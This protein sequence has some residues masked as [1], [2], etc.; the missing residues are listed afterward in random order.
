M[1]ANKIIDASHVQKVYGMLSDGNNV[2][3]AHMFAN[4]ANTIMKII[5]DA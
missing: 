2:L 1:F 3:R 4:P 5:K